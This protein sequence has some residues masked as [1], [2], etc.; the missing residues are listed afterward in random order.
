MTA[1]AVE[2]AHRL[3]PVRHP[4]SLTRVTQVELRKMFNTRS[5]PPAA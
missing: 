2:N 4:V 1:V 5:W 3:A